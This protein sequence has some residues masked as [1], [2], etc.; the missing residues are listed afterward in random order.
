MSSRF[1]IS[2]LSF[3]ASDSSATRLGW[4]IA[5]RVEFVVSQVAR[6]KAGAPAD[7][8]AQELHG[9]LRRMGVVPNVRELNEYADRIANLPTS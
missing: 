7:E 9:R 8:I 5:Q 1:S 3:N 2:G 6:Q 4:Q